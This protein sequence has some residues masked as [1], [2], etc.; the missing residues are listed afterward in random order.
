MTSIAAQ[1]H[2]K[3]RAWLV[4]GM[5]RGGQIGLVTLLAACASFS[6]DGGMDA[7]K[8]TVG[9]ELNA[10]V[11]ALR[12]PE[13]AEAARATV[14]RLLKGQL[15]AD[16][17]V[18]IAL[19]N[20]RSLQ[21]AYNALGIAEAGFVQASLP[22][23]PSISLSRIAGSGAWEIEGQIALNLL[24]LVTTPVRAE[25]AKDRFRQAQLQAA[26]ET[27]RIATET[28]RS[29]YRAVAA[30]QLVG[31]LAQARVAAE[32][33]AELAKRLGESGAVNV[34]DQVRQ[35]VFYAELA[36][37]LGSARQ[38]AVSERE[39]LI[40][41]MG[42]WGEDLAFKLPGKLPNL[43]AK[44]RVLAAVE[45]DA[46]RR[47]LDLRI[48]RLELEA[49]ATSY[50]LTHATRFIS[51]LDV[52]GIS[53]TS[54]EKDG[55]RLNQQGGEVELQIP[56]FDLGEVRLREAEQSYMQALNR[57]AAKAVEVRSQARA[58]Y[59]AYRSSYD[60][61]RHLRREVL[62][63][64]KI[65]SDESLLLYNAMQI[66]VFSLLME[67]RQ[68]IASRVAAIK[69]EEDFWLAETNL[70]AALLGGDMGSTATENN[71]PMEAAAEPAAGHERSGA[72]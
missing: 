60:I 45:K 48:E 52:S 23:N 63:L 19:L 11:A 2:L 3:L 31:A 62:P 37:D 6:P 67:A 43:P 61:A 12:S 36:A 49:L 15:T 72:R 21:A 27:L 33:A 66:D 24:E 1:A 46:V 7:V 42:L 38:R 69:A 5:L 55:T 71:A 57:L 51:L 65:I 14:T 68:T 47:R 8:S 29:F 39:G 56:L 17:A 28:R 16:A 18:Q 70:S 30:Q 26:W 54:R 13:D 58:A 53:N 44:A 25:I 35:Q 41:A 20:N 32:T 64:R 50:G 59:Q 9:S 40:R 22:P 4:V 10:E 34:L